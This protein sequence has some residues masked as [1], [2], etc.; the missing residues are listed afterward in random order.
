MTSPIHIKARITPWDDAA[1]VKAFEHARDQVHETDVP[2]GDAGPRVE[3]LLRASGYP[4]AR[5][6]VARTVEEALEHTSH[7]LVSRDG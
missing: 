2:D 3:R 5:V 6:Q 4:N 1:F 7:W